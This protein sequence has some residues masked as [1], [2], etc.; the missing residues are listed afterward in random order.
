MR[1][2]G[3]ST[4]RVY[5]IRAA[6]R[7]RQNLSRRFDI[8]L[9]HS[10]MI[11]LIIIIITVIHCANQKLYK[12]LDITLLLLLMAYSYTTRITLHSVI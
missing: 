12:N 3:M 6:V 7:L 10:I 8:K 4:S 5:A 1:T 11:M 2:R 9:L